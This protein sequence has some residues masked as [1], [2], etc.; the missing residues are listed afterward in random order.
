MQVGTICTRDVITIDAQSPLADAA[1]LMRDKH[2]GS[3]VVTCLSARGVEVCGMVTD[4]DVV[5]D[6]IAREAPVGALRIGDLASTELTLIS[7]SAD[8]DEAITV[9]QVS[10]VRRLLVSN[11]DDQLCGLLS[12]DDVMQ[13]FAQQMGGLAKI[14]TSGRER[15]VGEHPATPWQPG[16]RFPPV[17][18]AA[19]SRGTP[20]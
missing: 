13:A 7:E 11:S 5:L 15:E 6:A 3:L 2:V 18:T 19:W 10:G 8:L 14:M 4:R 1:S 20:S 16:V 17:G 9:M 12:I